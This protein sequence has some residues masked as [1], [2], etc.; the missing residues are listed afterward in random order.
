MLTVPLT[1]K[2]IFLMIVKHLLHPEIVR[3]KGNP[4]TIFSKTTEIS[5][6]ESA[7]PELSADS[8]VAVLVSC[9]STK[10]LV[11]RHVWSL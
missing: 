11:E 4:V 1:I 6:N 9:R 8:I 7:S 5:Y 10:L 3:L 2:F